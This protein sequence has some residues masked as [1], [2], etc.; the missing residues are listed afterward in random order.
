MI[1][2]ILFTIILVY[3]LIG[4]LIVIFGHSFDTENAD[5]LIVLGNCLIDNKPSLILKNRL[6]KAL[7][8]I[9]KNDTCKIIL[10]GGVTK[11]NTI[12]EAEYMKTYLVKNGID[13]NRII[14]EDKS[15]D[16]VENIMNCRSIIESN[17]KVVVLS[18]SYHTLRA[19]MICKLCGLKVKTIQAHTPIKDFIKHIGIEIL[20]IPIHYR[21][22]TKKQSI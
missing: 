19:R 6:R 21:R 18:S 17:S 15:I 9:D 20:Y 5:Y 12:S 4:I 2:R 16:T 8:Y 13:N 1:I 7:Q 22:I 10:S 11:N 14:L 3:L